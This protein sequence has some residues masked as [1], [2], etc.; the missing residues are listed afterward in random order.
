VKKEK[1][2][3]EKKKLTKVKK[4]EPADEITKALMEGKTKGLINI[5]IKLSQIGVQIT[6]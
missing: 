6:N 2:K 3:L 5:N 1:K 4:E